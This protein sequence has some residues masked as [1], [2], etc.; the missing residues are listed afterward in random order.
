M[1]SRLVGLLLA[2]GAGVLLPFRLPW[3]IP[4]AMLQCFAGDAMRMRLKTR[5]FLVLGLMGLAGFTA[6]SKQYDQKLFAGMRWRWS[7]GS[8]GGRRLAVSAVQNA[9]TVYNMWSV[10]GGV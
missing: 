4:R 8:R 2:I 10:N 9:P 3:G 7:G 5:L 1:K 6:R